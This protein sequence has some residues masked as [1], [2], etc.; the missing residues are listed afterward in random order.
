MNL[1]M[2]KRSHPPKGS[3]AS[4]ESRHLWR[5]S[6]KISRIAFQ[7]AEASTCV[8]IAFVALPAL[9]S[10]C[11][12]GHTPHRRLQSSSSCNQARWAR[13]SASSACPLGAVERCL[14]AARSAPVLHG[15][16]GSIHQQPPREESRCYGTATYRAGERWNLYKSRENAESQ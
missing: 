1:F 10:S 15:P 8:M 3:S 11:P 14:A 7:F 12:P 5:H 13:E 4:P 16:N 2:A 6:L 9:Q